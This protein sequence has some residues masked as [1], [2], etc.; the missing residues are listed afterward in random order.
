MT[1]ISLALLV[2]RTSHMEAS[3]AFYRAIGLSL[4][5]EKHGS[6]PIHYSCQMGE[7]VVE[8]Y[9]ETAQEILD[10]R[11][12]GAT[13]LGFRVESLKTTV[14]AI[15]QTG[16]RLLSPPKATAWGRRAVALDPDGRAVELNEPPQT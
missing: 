12:G 16:A 3:L 6:G 5:E 8:I 9:P 14:I 15:E 2:L 1:Q 7:T 10:Y 4:V 13:M 11:R